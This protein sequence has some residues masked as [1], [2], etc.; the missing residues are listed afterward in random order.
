M[1]VI[2]KVASVF[3]LFLQAIQHRLLVL[4][5]AEF[6]VKKKKD[7]QASLEIQT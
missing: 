3:Y 4:T 6:Q 1:Y 5:S 7:K 2:S